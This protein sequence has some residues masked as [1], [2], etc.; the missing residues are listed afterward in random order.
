MSA[1]NTANEVVVQPFGARSDLARLPFEEPPRPASK[2]ALLGALAPETY[3]QALVMAVALSKSPLVPKAYQAKEQ[4]RDTAGD[5]VIAGMWGASLGL[6]WLHAMKS[7]AVINGS[8]GIWGDVGYALMLKSKQ[9]EVFEQT[10]DP[11][12]KI[13]TCKIKRRG[14][15][16]RVTTFSMEQARQAKLDSKATYQLYPD[17]MCG[18]RAFWRAAK[19]C[20]AD[21]FMG[22]DGAEEL[23]DLP[24]Q[25]A[26]IPEPKAL[27]P[28]AKTAADLLT[29]AFGGGTKPALEAG[30]GGAQAPA[31]QESAGP[32]PERVYIKEVVPREYQRKDKSTGTVFWIRLVD[33]PRKISTFS[34]SFAEVA[35]SAIG[36][37]WP[38]L[39]VATP[40]QS[41]NPAYKDCFDLQSIV[42]A[43]E[44]DSAGAPPDAD[45]ADGAGEPE[46]E[47]P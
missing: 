31:Q 19:P 18:W 11:V 5:I 9:L 42:L 36:D 46:G 6:D 8:A 14:Y 23:A 13:A 43:P 4:R 29:E 1:E 41:K 12:K 45:P 28:P 47:A 30:P 15:A 27:P 21:V 40:S 7:I 20:F 10:W 35:R 33:D 16:E 25:V 32:E 34:E 17:V 44:Q 2:N 38:A 26:P 24:P 3:E 22:L 39:I 37:A